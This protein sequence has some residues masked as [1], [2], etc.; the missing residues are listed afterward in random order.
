VFRIHAP[1]NGAAYSLFF[2][3]LEAAHWRGLTW[4]AFCELDGSDQSLVIAHY[5]TH[6]Q[7]EAVIAADAAKRSKGK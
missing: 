1:R 5:R 3:W 2:E 4:E 6:M 7:L